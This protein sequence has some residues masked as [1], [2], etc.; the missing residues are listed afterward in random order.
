MADDVERAERVGPFHAAYPTIAH[1][2][3]QALECRRRAREHF[4]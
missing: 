4:D 3:E 2:A 1:T